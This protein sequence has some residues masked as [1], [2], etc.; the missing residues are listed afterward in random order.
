M[1][2]W[3]F[4]TRFAA[5]NQTMYQTM[6]SS[7]TPTTPRYSAVQ[8]AGSEVS[9]SDCA[10]K[11]E[12]CRECAAANYRRQSAPQGRSSTSAPAN[13]MQW[14]PSSMPKAPSSSSKR[15]PAPRGQNFSDAECVAVCRAFISAKND[16]VRG[17]GQK[18]DDYHLRAYNWYKQYQESGWNPRTPLSIAAKFADIRRDCGKFSKCMV[19]A[20]VRKNMGRV[21]S[22]VVICDLILFLRQNLNHLRAAKPKG[23]MTRQF[24][25][26]PWTI[27]KHWIKKGSPLNTMNVGCF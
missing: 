12:R 8:S 2:P 23:S 7:S 17:S 26:E 11:A 10:G 20:K 21:A 16:N 27:G 3:H 14:T 22:L 18:V 13:A 24:W 5:C 25:N 4:Q 1:Q 19:L 9:C 6:F 15:V